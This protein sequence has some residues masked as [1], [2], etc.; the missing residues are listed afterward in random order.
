MMIAD[1]IVVRKFAN[2]VTCLEPCMMT[3]K[4]DPDQV[5]ILMGEILDL[6]P[7]SIFAG[8]DE[9]CEPKLPT[10]DAEADEENDGFDFIDRGTPVSKDADFI[11]EEEDAN[12]S[13]AIP[14]LTP[15]LPKH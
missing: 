12:P 14:G 3:G 5:K 9:T 4:I 7:M 8:S 13:G 6:W 10:D 11:S 2:A 1:T 15:A